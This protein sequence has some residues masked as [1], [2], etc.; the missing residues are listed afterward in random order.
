MKIWLILWYATLVLLSTLL[1]FC[2]ANG[3]AGA[4]VEGDALTSSATLLV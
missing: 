2:K 3:G 4:L 1:P